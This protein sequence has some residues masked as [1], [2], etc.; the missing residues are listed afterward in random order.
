MNLRVKA[1]TTFDRRILRRK[2]WKRLN[3][4]PLKRA[5]LL[6]RKIA[7]RSIRRRKTDKPAPAG[8]PPR[9]RAPG[10]PLRKI[11]SVVNNLATE[12]IVGPVGL[13]DQEPAPEVHEKGLQ[14]RRPVLPRWYLRL[15]PRARRQRPKPR[16]KLRSVDYPPRPF[17]EPALE[18]A[19]PK[20]PELWRNSLN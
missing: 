13:G 8:S 10:D 4:S 6:V 20:L 12:V 9:T 11:F 1:R 7:R 19:Q 5:G 2:N 14:V 15:P 16:P 3:N 18:V 17:M